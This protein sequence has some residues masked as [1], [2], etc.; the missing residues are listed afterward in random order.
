MGHNHSDYGSPKSILFLMHIFTCLMQ[1]R[2]YL[3]VFVIRSPYFELFEI[4]SMF[5]LAPSFVNHHR[6]S[7][8]SSCFCREDCKGLVITQCLPSAVTN[9]SYWE[10]WMSS[11]LKEWNEMVQ[12]NVPLQMPHFVNLWFEI[13]F[14][15]ILPSCRVI[16]DNT[17]WQWFSKIQM[18]FEWS[19]RNVRAGGSP[20]GFHLKQVFTL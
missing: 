13:T 20:W 1:K 14:Q 6:S 2:S 17:F 11:Q 10:L 5:Y 19:F 18:L 4:L 3:E 15:W 8:N 9:T 7:T 16:C 12:M